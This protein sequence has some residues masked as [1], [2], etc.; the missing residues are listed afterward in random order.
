LGIEPQSE[1]LL[2]AYLQFSWKGKGT[3]PSGYDVLAQTQAGCVYIERRNQVLTSFPWPFADIAFLLLHSG[4]K[5]ATHY[6]LQTMHLPKGV[7]LLPPLVEQAKQAFSSVQSSVLV[8]AVNAYQAQLAS[9]GLIAKHSLVQLDLLTKI[10]GV[11]A[12]K[13]CGALGADILLLLVQL[14]TLKETL[15]Y[16]QEQSWDVLATQQELYLGPALLGLDD[17]KRPSCLIKDEHGSISI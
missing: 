17:K 11:L 15:L 2:R 16:L 7:E 14:S 13:G 12:A 5:L 6:H 8:Q 4:Q 10:P 1:S 3:S 9:M